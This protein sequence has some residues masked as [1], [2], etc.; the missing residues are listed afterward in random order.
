MDDDFGVG[1]GLED[2]ALGEEKFTEFLIVVD[3]PVENDPYGA[4]LVRDGLVAGVEVNDGETTKA[5]A[6]WAGKIKPFVVRAAMLDGVG[7]GLEEFGSNARSPIKR[8]F[9]ANAAH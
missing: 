3:F 6:D 8:E 9:S 5:E 4:I 1:L 2:V 7:H